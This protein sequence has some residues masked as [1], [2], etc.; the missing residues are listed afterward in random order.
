VVIARRGD[1]TYPLVVLLGVLPY[2]LLSTIISGSAN[3]LVSNAMLIRR[4]YLPRELFLVAHIGSNFVVFLLSLLVVIPFVVYYGIAPG[5]GL[6]W[7]GPGVLLVV[8]FATGVG[9]VVSCMN[10]LYR[11]VGYVMSVLLRILFYASPVIYPVD[12]VPE[13][14]RALYFL[15]P[16]AVYL[17][18]IRSSVLGQPLLVPTEH[19]VLAVV[20]A[21]AML[22]GGALFFGR[23]ERKVVKFL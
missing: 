13:R 3:A 18:M 20:V 21:F 15:N 16:L 4:V 11:D 10:V 5:V 12:M 23:W 19:V 2:N 7:L 6:L 8:M 22:F 17:S 1:V 14:L 9:L